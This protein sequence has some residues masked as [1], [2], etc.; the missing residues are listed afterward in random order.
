MNVNRTLN[1]KLLAI[2]I[3]IF[4]AFAFGIIWMV[5][6]ITIPKQSQFIPEF[7]T[8]QELVI[9]LRPGNQGLLITGPIIKPLQFRIEPTNAIPIDWRKLLSMDPHTDIIVICQ[10]DENGRLKIQNI[11]MG[12][13]AEAGTVIRNAI[14]TWNYTPCKTG[15]IQFWFNLP[16]KGKKLIVDSSRLVRNKNIPDHIPVTNGLLYVINNLPIGD[17]RY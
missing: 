6:W 7:Q 12:G 14:R 11:Y 8:E 10:I 1:I 13:H 3:P 16:S 15:Q 2:A 17:V 4:L 9:P 5:C